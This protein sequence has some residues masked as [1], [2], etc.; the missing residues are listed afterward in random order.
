[1][2]LQNK[3]IYITGA[4]RG[5]GK[6]LALEAASRGANVFA[7]CRSADDELVVELKAKGAKEA[8]VLKLDAS[9]F[10]N[11]EDF[12]KQNDFNQFPIDVW[13][14]N[15]GQLTGGLIEEQDPAQIY[16]MLQ[17]NLNAVIHLSQKAIQTMLPRSTGKIVNNSSVSGKMFLPCAST[18][19]ASKA[20]VV[21]FTESIKQELRNTG[22]STLLLITP[23][24]DTR[25][26]SDIPKMYEKNLEV[27]SWDVIPPEKWASM[28][29]DAIESDEDVLWPK[30][31]TYWGV[32]LGHH[33]PGLLEKFVQPKFKR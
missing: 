31:E 24:V 3:N 11:I 4:N 15:A 21:A 26:H 22:L 6:A 5:I 10:D 20:G 19:A 1:M 7:V 17:V 23:G 14:N 27:G 12:F 2:E 8:R 29:M 13:V 32:K 25:M 33:F 9:S 30:G 18:Y 28:V 16:K